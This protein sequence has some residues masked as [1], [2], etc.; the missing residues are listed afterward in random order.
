MGHD[1]YAKAA[2]EADNP[3]SKSLL[4][5]LAAEELQHRDQVLRMAESKMQPTSEESSNIEDAVRQVFDR[6]SARQRKEWK[7][8]NLSV[9]ERAIELERESLKLY[10]DLLSQASE[11]AEISLLEELIEEEIRHRD[12]LDNVYYYLNDSADWLSMEE[13]R[14]WNWMNV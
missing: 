3:L 10:R 4:Q 14:R 6:F 2:D 9:Y 5:R 11:P 13:S 7:G 8:S 1:Y 12:A